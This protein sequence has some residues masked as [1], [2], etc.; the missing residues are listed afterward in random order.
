MLVK[1]SFTFS[2]QI[3]SDAALYKFELNFKWLSGSFSIP[4]ISFFFFYPR[5][6]IE[7]FCSFGER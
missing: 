2:L 6:E 1:F 4:E 3:S 7:P 5:P